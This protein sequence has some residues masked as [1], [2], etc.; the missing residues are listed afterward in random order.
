MT[1]AN[2]SADLRATAFGGAT[3]I[4]ETNKGTLGAAVTFGGLLG[5]EFEA[6]RVW[7]GSLENVPVVDVQANLTTYMANLVAC[8]CARYR[9]GR[10]RNT[11]GRR[12]DCRRTARGR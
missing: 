3:R 6:A 1:P 11:T 12:C 5:I 8:R 10:P 4:N 9:G 2:A 7:L